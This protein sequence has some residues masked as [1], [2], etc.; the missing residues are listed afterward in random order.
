MGESSLK[1]PLLHLGLQP[2]HHLVDPRLPSTGT[3]RTAKLTCHARQDALELSDDSDVEVHPN[4][5]KRS[6]IRAKQN[7]I[8]MEREQRRHEIATRKYEH[9]LN[10]GLEK[11]LSDLLAALKTRADDAGSSDAPAQ[12]AGELA[13][14]AVMESA[15][16][17]A[18][19]DKLPPRPE[20]VHEAQ[21]EGYPTTYSKMLVT[22]L[23]H[24]NKALDEKKVEPEKR[25]GAMVEELGVHLR[26]IK[27]AQRKSVERLR[28]LEAEEGKKITSESYATGFDSSHVNKSAATA[29]GK[30]TET[31]Q[32]LLNPG[33]AQGGS[34]SA[35]GAE[36]ATAGDDDEEV[37]ASPDAKKFA[38]I[39]VGDYRSS[40]DFITS[41]PHIVTERETDGLLVEAFNAGLEGDDQAALRCVHQALLLQ[42]CRALGKDGVA[43]FFKRITTKGEAHRMFFNDVQETYGKIRVRTREIKKERKAEE[44]AGGVEQIQLH[45]VEPGTTINITVPEEG[46]AVEEVREQRSIFEGFEPDMKKA[47]ASGSLDEVNKVLGAMKSDDAEELVGLLGDVSLS[48]PR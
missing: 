23:D 24:A 28:E 42:Y 5:D 2:R 16:K 20:G 41:H 18:E 43:L 33:F 31:S 36:A 40:L 4:V 30:E 14:K 3:T 39:G 34:G 13:F 29:K 38:L 8:H 7:Q 1:L 17:N 47:L 35:G 9:V 46:S 44:E 26:D 21:G 25:F 6:F 11:R 45:A 15:P 32:E 48:L 10:A 12:R 19:E 27:D 22:V 37:E